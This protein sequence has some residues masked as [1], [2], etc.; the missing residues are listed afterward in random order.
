LF[1]LSQSLA[2]TSDVYLYS[3]SSVWQQ[4]QGLQ[5]ALYLTFFWTSPWVTTFLLLLRF[6]QHYTLPPHYC[7]TPHFATL[8]I[9]GLFDRSKS[10]NSNKRP[11]TSPPDS[12]RTSFQDSTPRHTQEQRRL[13]SYDPWRLYQSGP[14]SAPA[15]TA[16]SDPFVGR[17]LRKK[18]SLLSLRSMISDAEPIK[19][20]KIPRASTDIS[21]PSMAQQRA[22]RP[23][24]KSRTP[25][26]QERPELHLKTSSSMSVFPKASTTFGPI[27]D[28]H[29]SEPRGSMD[30]ATR[31]LNAGQEKFA[32]HLRESGHRLKH[33]ASKLSLLSNMSTVPEVEEVKVRPALRSPCRRHGHKSCGCSREIV[34]TITEPQSFKHV[35]HAEREQFK[36]M[37]ARSQNDLM[38]DV[39]VLRAGQ[40]PS[41]DLNGIKAEEIPAS[42][43]CSLDAVRALD[44]TPTRRGH[45]ND[46]ALPSPVPS[47]TSTS[48]VDSLSSRPES[49]TS[50]ESTTPCRLARSFS[51]P[52]PDR[53][54]PKMAHHQ[55]TSSAS[56]DSIGAGI[57]YHERF[58]K[59]SIKR[60]PSMVFHSI[61]PIDC[62]SVFTTSAPTTPAED[63]L[64]Y[65]LAPVESF[66]FQFTQAFEAALPSV[67]EDD[68][69]ISNPSL[70]STPPPFIDAYRTRK[71]PQ[72]PTIP[73]RV[74]SQRVQ[75]ARPVK[76]TRLAVTPPRAL[77]HTGT[78]RTMSAK[79]SME[80]M[81]E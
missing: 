49:A 57:A 9:M 33:S 47:L 61:A 50:Q 65:T 71:L 25:S 58:G 10:R 36:N 23:T 64:T 60:R 12:A 78:L 74:N 1:F 55:L 43:R 77:R 2:T 39:S 30:N 7:I 41:Q 48:S 24:L 53:M 67:S 46:S 72:P 79:A 31:V 27:V 62:E 28:S 8:F 40:K 68:G 54:P 17:L 75:Q 69:I 32:R 51:R 38:A 3:R 37:A 20:S 15:S 81:R 59:P 35:T 76:L 26:G 14:V 63:S 52:F 45:Y 29:M 56:C 16:T 11:A 73:V 22:E 80:V 6:Q 34:C 19:T 42:T 4:H 13:K 18:A 44:T 5:L 21:R 66:P 70:P